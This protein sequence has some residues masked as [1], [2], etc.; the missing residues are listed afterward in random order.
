MSVQFV[1]LEIPTKFK[2]TL[3]N[4]KLVGTWFLAYRSLAGDTL[5]NYGE[6]YK[7]IG[8]AFWR[9]LN[10]GKLTRQYG[11][12]HYFVTSGGNYWITYLSTWTRYCALNVGLDISFCWSNLNLR[13]KLGRAFQYSV[14][15]TIQFVIFGSIFIHWISNIW[16]YL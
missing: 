14:A 1:N 5:I 11:H 13:I 4:K 6:Q 3:S 10:N 2:Q 9:S 12:K 8:E 15:S 16:L 7:I